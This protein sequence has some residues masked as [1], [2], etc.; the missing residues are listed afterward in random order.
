MNDEQLD[1]LTEL[2]RVWIFDANYTQDKK[3]RIKN[4]RRVYDCLKQ[5]FEA[6]EILSD[7]VCE[8]AVDYGE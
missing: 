6:T 7:K 8:I 5:I 1:N 3:V 2:M 4:L